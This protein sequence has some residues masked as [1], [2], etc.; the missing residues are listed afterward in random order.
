MKTCEK[1]GCWEDAYSKVDKS[2]KAKAVEH[3]SNCF[4]AVTYTWIKQEEEESAEFCYYH[5]K[6]AKGKI[7]IVKKRRILHEA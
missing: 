1:V 3:F 7:T 6:I 5:T 2:K 4:G